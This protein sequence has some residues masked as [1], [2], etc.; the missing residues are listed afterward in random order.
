MAPEEAMFQRAKALLEESRALLLHGD[1]LLASG[2]RSPYYL[3]SKMFSL[4]GEGQFLAGELLYS[5][6]R[7]YD[8]DGFGGMEVSAVPLIGAIAR[9]SHDHGDKLQG[10]YVKKA[11]KD[12][13][14]RKKIEGH[15]PENGRVVIIDDV[16]TTGRSAREAVQ[17]AEDVGLTVVAV[18]AL[19]VTL[20]VAQVL[21][22][23]PL[24]VAEEAVVAMLVP[25]VMEL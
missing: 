5:L 15:V 16:V 23:V 24:Q 13:G 4:D 14:P 10:F 2:L 17:A 20:R 3:D 7:E 21:A 25:L 22:V 8:I 12:H 19:V 11:A 1:Y 18:V 6:I 9:A